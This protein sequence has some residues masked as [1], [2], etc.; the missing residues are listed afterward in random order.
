MA[1]ELRVNTL[2]DAAGA[3]SVAIEYVA[4]GSAK[5]W[6]SSNQASL[7]DSFNVASTTDNQSADTTYTYTNAMANAGYAAG[8][9]SVGP[10]SGTQ[11]GT[12]SYNS[13]AAGSIRVVTFDESKN[14]N[15]RFDTAYQA[16]TISGDLA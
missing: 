11:A 14:A 7:I 9:G 12:T 10:S 2:K 8:S 6:A 13:V 4:G 5:A 1:S 15:G 16:V 3:N